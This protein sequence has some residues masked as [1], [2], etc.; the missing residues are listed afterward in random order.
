MEMI[1]RTNGSSCF[2]EE[3]TTFW[4]KNQMAFSGFDNSVNSDKSNDESSFN[5]SSQ[6]EKEAEREPYFRSRRRISTFEFAGL[7]AT[8]SLLKVL[9]STSYASKQNNTSISYHETKHCSNRFMTLPFRTQKLWKIE[10]K[11]SPRAN[12]WSIDSST[13]DIPS[14]QR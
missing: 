9:S 13:D 10:T 14:N 11:S 6:Y 5:L 1:L 4:W 12:H 8:K 3:V 2:R 7:N